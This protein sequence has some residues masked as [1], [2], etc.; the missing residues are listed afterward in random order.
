MKNKKYFF[1][2]IDGTLTD[3]QTGIIVPSARETLTKLQENGHFVALCS[4][5]AQYKARIILKELGLSNM[6]CCGGGGIVIDDVII[7][8]EPLDNNK[9]RALI[10]ECEANDIG[11]LI[12]KD[13]TEKVYRKDDLF[14][15]QSGGRYEPTQYIVDK[16]LD[17][18]NV[19]TIY[20][21]YVS[22]KP[23]DEHLLPSLQN[24]GHLRFVPQY[25]IIQHDKK[26][27][28]IIETMKLLNADIKD[29]VVF[30]DDTNDLIMFDERW[31]SIAMGNATDNKLKEKANY[32][33]DTSVNDG[34][35]K[36][37]QHFGW[38]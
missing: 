31:T 38:I 2:D 3:K 34:V 33:T 14:M 18:N 8:N 12:T 19:N 24:I 23:E 5:R 20:K 7:K 9:V 21:A 37:C 6:V 36:A 35:M 27:K 13:D 29:V 26:D 17:V 28:G 22:V 15:E 1:F 25:L 16:E 11:Y 32:V 30:G 4:G 10:K